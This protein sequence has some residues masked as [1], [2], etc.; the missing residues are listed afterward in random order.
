MQIVA[1]LVKIENLCSRNKEANDIVKEANATDK[2]VNE[3]GLKQ[4]L[5][6]AMFL[7]FNKRHLKKIMQIGSFLAET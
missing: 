1:F 3:K 5:S 2:E 6:S 7:K 4:S